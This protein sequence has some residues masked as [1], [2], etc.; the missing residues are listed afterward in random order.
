VSQAAQSGAENR[1]LRYLWARAR[2][3]ELS[4]YGAADQSSEQIAR[5]TDLG[6]IHHLL[7]PYTSFVAV[8]EVVRATPGAGDDV[9]QP[10][11]LPVGVTDLAV[12]GSVTQGSEPG[13][14]WLA[15][16]LALVV[17]ARHL[18]GARRISSSLAS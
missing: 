7:T 2:I 16:A 18:I 13:L 4:D 11:P 6:L 9:A 14:L 8:H 1:A 3:A 10:L 17:L 12:G 15:A 5:I